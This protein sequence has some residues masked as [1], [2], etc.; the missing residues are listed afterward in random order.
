MPWTFMSKSD[1]SLAP[2]KTRI[3]ARE[4]IR[5]ADQTAEVR[6]GPKQLRILPLYTTAM[7]TCD[8]DIIKALFTVN[9]RLCDMPNAEPRHSEKSGAS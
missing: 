6:K 9:S 5:E 4:S 8:I 3:Q 1:I 2:T 7:S